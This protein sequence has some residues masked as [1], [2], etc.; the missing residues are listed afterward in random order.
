MHTRVARPTTMGNKPSKTVEF[1]DKTEQNNN[2][3][4]EGNTTINQLTD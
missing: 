1:A 4:D 3:I 2:N